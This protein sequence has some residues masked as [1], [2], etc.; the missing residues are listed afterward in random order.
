MLDNLDFT[1]RFDG[2]EM[3]DDTGLSPNILAKALHEL[4]KLNRYLGGYRATTRVLD[5]LLRSAPFSK[6]RI[7]DVGTGIGDYPREFV[8]WGFRHRVDVSVMAV[9]ISLPTVEFAR[10]AARAWTPEEGAR[11]S[12]TAGDAR[13]LAYPPGAFDIA[14]SALF[15]HHLSDRDAVDVLNRMSRIARHGVIVND[16]HR[17]RIAYY[18]LRALTSSFPFSE[19]VRHDGPVSVRRAF[20][21]DELERIGRM[22]AIGDFS[23]RWN[24]AFRWILTNIRCPRSTTS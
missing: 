2:L 24:W 11:V 5:E 4:P 22:A 8:R 20:T 3:M 7:L 17:S 15:F 10:E 6:L 21:R 23:I 9:D 16:I 19:M 18:G 12:F 1:R 13:T 14:T